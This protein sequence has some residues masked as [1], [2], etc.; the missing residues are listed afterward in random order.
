MSA[1]QESAIQ[2]G[3]LLRAIDG[4]VLPLPGERWIGPIEASDVRALD[5]AI[6]PVLDL[7]CGPGRHTEALAQRGLVVLGIDL[8]SHAVELA[9][10]KGLPVLER[11][12]YGSIPKAGE[13]NS[14]LLLDGNIGI[15]GNPLQLLSHVASLLTR[16]GVI[17]VDVEDQPSGQQTRT[18]R[19]EIEGVG[20]PWFEWTSVG[21]DGIHDLARESGMLL[22]DS[23][24]ASERYFCVLRKSR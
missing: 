10:A 18:V 5:S 15:G 2:K 3:A 11:S 16:E 9:R 19:L 8:S 17:V 21:V 14:A 13:W 24:R 22:V 20:G 4:Q 23:W 6:A 1:L 7:G 12:I